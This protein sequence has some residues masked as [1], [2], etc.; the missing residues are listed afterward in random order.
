MQLQCKLSCKSKNHL[1]CS[2]GKQKHYHSFSNAS[3]SYGSVLTTVACCECFQYLFLY[4]QWICRFWLLVAL[5]CRNDLL[6]LEEPLILFYLFLLVACL[7]AW[8]FL[9]LCGKILIF[10]Q[11]VGPQSCSPL[12][13]FHNRLSENH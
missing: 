7:L 1:Q 6:S 9:N 3:D 8:V 11:S 5:R 4:S 13:C 12:K 10:C 2:A